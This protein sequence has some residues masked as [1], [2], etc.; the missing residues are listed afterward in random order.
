MS[1]ERAKKKTGTNTQDV[2]KFVTMFRGFGVEV[3]LSQDNG[4]YTAV[5]D[6]GDGGTIEAYFDPSGKFSGFVIL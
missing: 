2:E 1:G 6:D 5:V 4:Q 3:N